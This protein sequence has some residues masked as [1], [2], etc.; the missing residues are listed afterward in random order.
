MINR[1]ASVHP[2]G[3]IHEVRIGKTVVGV[4]DKKECIAL[5]RELNRSRRKL[6]LVK[7]LFKDVV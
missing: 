7:S 5:K 3:R 4:S 2:H 1:N 6:R